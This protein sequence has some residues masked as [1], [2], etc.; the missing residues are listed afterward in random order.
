MNF[1]KVVNQILEQQLQILPMA[2]P[3]EGETVSQASER[4]AKNMFAGAWIDRQLSQYGFTPQEA[5][6]FWQLTKINKDKGPYEQ[7]YQQA[8]Q[9]I[10]AEKQQKSS[11]KP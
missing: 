11:Q 6:R 8:F 1:D 5:D 2:P 7:V 10:M 4:M 9:Q 3:Q